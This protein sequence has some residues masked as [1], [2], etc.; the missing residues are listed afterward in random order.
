MSAVPSAALEALLALRA[1]LDT[2]SFS[3][4]G[5]LLAG[6]L[7]PVFRLFSCSAVSL[8]FRDSGSGIFSVAVRGNPDG[9]T[10]GPFP[11]SPEEMSAACRAAENAFFSAE[12]M[13]A[14]LVSTR[15]A[16]HGLEK[17][18]TYVGCVDLYLLY[19]STVLVASS[20]P[21]FKI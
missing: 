2:L 5:G 15:S 8:L 4:A 20:Q 13:A 10:G 14:P 21:Y 18:V 17:S 12:E 9:S 19:T 6:V 16:F 7:P 3:D 1:S 11:A